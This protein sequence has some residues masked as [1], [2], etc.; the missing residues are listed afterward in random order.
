MKTIF[1]LIDFELFN[2]R[3][4]TKGK[5][6]FLNEYSDQKVINN[7]IL[8]LYGPNGS[9]KTASIDVLKLL[10]LLAT[11]N[12]ISA[13]AF[14]LVSF[15]KSV[16]KVKYNFLML[17][18]DVKYLI[19]YEI[20][21]KADSLNNK[22]IIL[23]EDLSSK[24]CKKDD[25]Y[26]KYGNEISIDYSSDTKE[27]ILS[28]NVATNNLYK[29]SLID[30]YA[31][32]AI[33][34]DK[35]SSF[36]FGKEFLKLL[37][38][39]NKDNKLNYPEDYKIIYNFTDYL[40]MNFFVLSN[41]DYSFSNLGLLPLFGLVKNET[42]E[43]IKGG[44]M[45]VDLVKPVTMSETNYEVVKDSVKKINL[46]M[47]SFIP[48]YK[49]KVVEIDNKSTINNEKM[50]TFSFYS[51]VNDEIIPLR[52]E[53]DGIKKIISICSALC[54][55]FNDPSI[56]LAIDEFDS[57][58]F[59]YLFGELLNVIDE[60]SKGQ[61]FFTSH[62]LRPLEV[63]N[64]KKIMFTTTNP[65]NRYIYFRALTPTNNL[66]DSYL[67]A[68]QVGGQKEEIYKE[69]HDSDIVFSFKKAGLISKWLR[70]KER[71]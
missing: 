56:F 50:V 52:D 61:L 16:A 18:D 42:L 32:R 30:L 36:I 6:N 67:R 70:Q 51:I 22:A 40:R 57:G 31:A 63:L 33:A 65:N 43:T 17:E 8:G 35:N 39:T 3:N 7:S 48:G 20:S 68:I 10:S 38:T 59:E 44:C 1:R 4:V 71:S 12:S 49:L 45:S 58:I 19:S 5:I 69:T 2:V 37:K 24:V 13:Y 26:T 14:D 46:I 66:R 11:E 62:N 41:K 55:L 25:K 53:S 47:P 29:K 15:Y 54:G 9:G 23:R 60:Y 64:Y 21:F 27:N 28:S 34:K